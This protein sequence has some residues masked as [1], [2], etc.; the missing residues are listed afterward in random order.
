MSESGLYGSEGTNEGGESMSIQVS[1]DQAMNRLS[2]E[3]NVPDMVKRF[4]TTDR[5]L[6]ILDSTFTDKEVKET[7][8][9]ALGVDNSISVTQ[10]KKDLKEYTKPYFGEK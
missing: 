1:P 9:D 6:N 8:Y 7:F 3:F 4:K 10:F 5:M 2:E